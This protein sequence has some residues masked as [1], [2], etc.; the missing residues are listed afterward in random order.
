MKRNCWEYKNCG[1]E[2]GGNR[3]HDLGECPAALDKRLDG[4]HGGKNA[5]RACW[6]VT[7]TFCKGELQGTFAQKFKSCVA[8]DFYK[9]VRIDEFPEFQLAAFLMQ[10]L[11]DGRNPDEDRSMTT[12]CAWCRKVRNEKGHWEKPG[13]ERSLAMVTH[14]ICPECLRQQNPELHDQILSEKDGLQRS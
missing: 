8:C 1:R 10:K 4:I 13:K 12:S 3:V 9:T 14:G 2:P 11:E 7:G 5:G 6:V